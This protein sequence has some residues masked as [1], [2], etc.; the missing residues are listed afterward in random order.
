MKILTRLPAQTGTTT[1]PFPTHKLEP[2]ELKFAPSFMAHIIC[3]WR[4]F[5]RARYRYGGIIIL[6]A[7]KKTKNLAIGFEKI[8]VQI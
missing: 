1:I 6:M 2:Y 5:H 7:I 3:S 8:G 4:I